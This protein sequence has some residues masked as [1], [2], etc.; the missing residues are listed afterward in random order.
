MSSSARALSYVHTTSTSVTESMARSQLGSHLVGMSF[1]FVR[2][3]L[4]F[5]SFDSAETCC[6]CISWQSPGL[7]HLKK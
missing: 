4:I 7:S 6:S 1:D 5:F 2:E 3:I